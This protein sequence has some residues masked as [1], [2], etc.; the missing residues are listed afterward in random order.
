MAKQQT[1]YQQKK[2]PSTT[3]E[4]NHWFKHGLRNHRLFPIWFQIKM[5]C[6]NPK[7]S[8]YKNYGG[9]GITICNKWRN[10]FKAFYDYITALPGYGEDGMTLDRINNDGN[11]EPGNMRWA[12]RKD[13]CI[14]RRKFKNNTTGLRGV[15]RDRNSFRAFLGMNGEKIHLGNHKTIIDAANARN[16]FIIKNSLWQYPIQNTLIA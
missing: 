9:R 16:L 6:V 13:Q 2:R 4:K 12:S 5:R 15:T 14:N 7:D 1:P 8:A 10:K 3:G 11:Y